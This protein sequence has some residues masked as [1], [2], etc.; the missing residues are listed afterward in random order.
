MNNSIRLIVHGENIIWV[1]RTRF[2]GIGEA[3]DPK[4]SPWESIVC[5]VL[6]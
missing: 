5:K 4:L 3:S 2:N 6:D 1:I